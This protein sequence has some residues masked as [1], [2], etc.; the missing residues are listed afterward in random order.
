M[1]RGL[2]LAGVILLVVLLVESAV[3]PG[4]GQAPAK[5]IDPSANK[6]RLNF[7]I[8]DNDWRQKEI[9]KI[10]KETGVHHEDKPSGYYSDN[11]GLL[12]KFA[13]KVTEKLGKLEYSVIA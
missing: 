1:S 9:R 2:L 5:A 6:M 4:Q 8:M 3:Q 12:L 7:D 11:F 13:D 10:A